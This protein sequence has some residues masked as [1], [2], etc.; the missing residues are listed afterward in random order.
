MDLPIWYKIV[1]E[2]EGV[3][4]TLFHGIK[5]SKVLKRGEWLRAENRLVSD[6]KGTKYLSAWHVMPSKEETEEYLKKFKN[7]ENKKIVECH[8]KDYAPK[9]HSRHEVYLA[10][11]IY[12]L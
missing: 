7:T 6:G 11:Y 2:K 5:G 1:N 9:K 10:D 4:K 3:L 12:I 8:V